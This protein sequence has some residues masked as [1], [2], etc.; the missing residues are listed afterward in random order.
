MYY[1]LILSVATTIRPQFDTVD[2]QSCTPLIQDSYSNEATTSSTD[3]HPRRIRNRFATM[4]IVQESKHAHTKGKMTHSS[5]HMSSVDL[6]E[7]RT[8][9]V[10]SHLY[11]T[12]MFENWLAAAPGSQVRP[13]SDSPSSRRIVKRSSHLTRPQSL[14]SYSSAMNTQRR[15]FSSSTSPPSFSQPPSNSASHGLSHVDAS[16][17]R[18]T[19][20]DVSGKAITKRTAWAQSIVLLP[21]NVGKLFKEDVKDFNTPKGKINHMY[22]P[23]PMYF[24]NFLISLY[25]AFTFRLS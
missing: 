21:E 13:A 2:T 12:E 22:G 14:A 18:P 25:S 20:V 6:L 7:S 23:C 1:N 9:A 5:T 15:Y 11:L 16:G 3:R 19:M 17:S 10:L 8:C 24:F 4:S